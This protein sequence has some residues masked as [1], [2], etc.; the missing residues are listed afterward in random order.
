MCGDPDPFDPSQWSEDCVTRKCRNCPTPSF[1]V[2]P[3]R[4]KETTSFSLWTTKDVD[5]RKQFNLF[6]V[7]K[8]LEDLAKELANDVAGMIYHV[9]SAAV[10]WAKLRKDVEELRPGIDV[11]TME[12]YQRNIEIFHNE[13][14][15]SLGYSANAICVAMY[16]IAIRYRQRDGEEAKTAM[17][18]LVSDD[19]QH[20]HQQVAGPFKDK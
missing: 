2:P 9:Y 16:P 20:G 11:L 5:G 18:I 12:D 6:E 10:A 1:P 19:L 14:P 13:A 3:G 15:T 8:T 7:T 17:L 4:E